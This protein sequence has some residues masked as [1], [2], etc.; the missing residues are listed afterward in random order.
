[1]S[2]YKARFEAKLDRF[3][4]TVTI[5]SQEVLAFVA[6]ADSNLRYMFLNVGEFNDTDRPVM[7]FYVKADTSVT[8]SDSV[9]YDGTAYPVR[10]I[11]KIWMGETLIAKLV[12]AAEDY[13]E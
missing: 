10:D 3:G 12:I 8:T 6:E 9:T 5:D 4:K 11:A 7:A 13:P 2:R 1:M